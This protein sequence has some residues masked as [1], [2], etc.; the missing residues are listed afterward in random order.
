MSSQNAFNCT[1]LSTALRIIHMIRNR[2][3][4]IQQAIGAMLFIKRHVSSAK[5][6]SKSRI[7]NWL[8]KCHK[9]T[10]DLSEHPLDKQTTRVCQTHCSLS[11]LQI[12]YLKYSKQE[13]I[14]LPNKDGFIK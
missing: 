6:L 7:F 2:T 10:S 8:R 3:Q 4:Y 12:F 5:E 14:N 9:F 11:I 13:F 1:S